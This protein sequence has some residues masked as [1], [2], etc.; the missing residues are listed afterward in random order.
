[1]DALWQTTIVVGGI[2]LGLLVG[3]LA[4]AGLFLGA[5]GRARASRE[6]RPA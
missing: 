3:R 1:V 5:V 6:D 4:L 2:A